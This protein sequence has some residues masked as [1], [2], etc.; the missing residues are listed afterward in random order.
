VR[1]HLCGE[2]IAR[3]AVDKGLPEADQWL[4]DF[5]AALSHPGAFDF[6]SMPARWQSAQK[7]IALEYNQ[8][9]R[10]TGGCALMQLK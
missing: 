6:Q 9:L 8:H 2:A 10:S 1:A 4:Q 5:Y 7:L 3:R